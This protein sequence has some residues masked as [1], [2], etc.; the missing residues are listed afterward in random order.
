MLSASIGIDSVPELNLTLTML[1]FT[2]A[3]LSR[4][5][6]HRYNDTVRQ[7]ELGLH[8]YEGKVHHLL[9]ELGQTEF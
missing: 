8:S 1:A 5:E 7:L 4:I 3:H 2:L 6:L 9:S